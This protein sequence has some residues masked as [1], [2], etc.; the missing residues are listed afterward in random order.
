MTHEEQVNK[1]LDR[2]VAI[3]G[4]RAEKTQEQ[5]ILVA[6]MLVLM[7]LSVWTGDRQ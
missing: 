2:A 4:P 7:D 5:T 3:L 6:L 1:Y